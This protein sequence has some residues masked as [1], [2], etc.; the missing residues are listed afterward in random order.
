MFEMRWEKKIDV[1]EI[2]FF[3]LWKKKIPEH[4]KV[5]VATLVRTTNWMNLISCPL[6]YVIFYIIFSVLHEKYRK[7]RAARNDA[8]SVLILFSSDYECYAPWR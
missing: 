7:R 4:N 2:R 5:E 6:Y 8:W 1:F 3:L